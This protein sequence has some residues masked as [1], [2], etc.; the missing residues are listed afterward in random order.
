MIVVLCKLSLNMSQ[1]P[2]IQSKSEL[3][4]FETKTSQSNSYVASQIDGKS[5]EMSSIGDLF[6]SVK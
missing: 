1:S 2:F 4:F 5:I 6:K 3:P